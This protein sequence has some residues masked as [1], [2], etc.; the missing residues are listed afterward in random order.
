MEKS[1][2]FELNKKDLKKIGKGVLIALGGALLTYATDIIPLVEWG[3]WKPVIVAFSSILIN[4][5]WKLLKS[6]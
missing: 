4:A 3:E 1:G 5:G 6:K 2:K